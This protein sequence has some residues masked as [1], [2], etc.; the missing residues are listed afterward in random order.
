MDQPP[1]T[2]IASM[3]KG[4][5]VQR[6]SSHQRS[7]PRWR[8]PQGR[9]NKKVAWCSTSSVPKHLICV[10]VQFSE[11][12]APVAFLRRVVAKAAV[13]I[14]LPQPLSQGSRWRPSAQQNHTFTHAH[15]H[16][17]IACCDQEIYK[18]SHLTLLFS[19]GVCE[20]KSWAANFAEPTRPLHPL[21]IQC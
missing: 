1:R 3:C 21:T 8:L 4:F 12:K 2:L 19:S 9:Q 5:R 7:P 11:Q 6:N 10:V 16:I 18:Q 20:K 13:K 15:N 14:P 17:H